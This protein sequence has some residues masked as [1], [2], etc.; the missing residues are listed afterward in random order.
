MYVKERSGQLIITDDARIH[1]FNIILIGK[2]YLD[3][4]YLL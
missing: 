4:K 3:S 1:A 2:D